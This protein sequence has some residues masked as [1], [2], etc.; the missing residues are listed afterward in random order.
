M[1][2]TVF[3]ATNRKRSG[4][5]TKITDYAGE[6]G[7]AGMPGRVTH[8]MAHVS[9]TDL[10]QLETGRIDRIDGVSPDAFSKAVQADLTGRKNLLIFLHGF[11]NGFSDSITRT[12]F[13]REWLALGGSDC[14]AV[15]FSW[16]SGGVIVSGESLVPGLLAAPMS[17]VLLTAGIVASPWAN[18]YLADQKAAMASAADVLSFLDR[19]HPIAQKVRARGGRVI[20]MA[21]S[22]GNLVLQSAL[23]RRAGMGL[24][25][26]L[27]FE[28]AIS[29]AADTA[30]E[31]M[32]R[33]P[34]WLLHLGKVSERVSVYH[35]RADVILQLSRK[36]NRGKRLGDAGPIDIAEPG[37]YPISRFRFV[38]CSALHDDG[39]NPSLDMSHQYYR[40]IPAVRDDIAN[41]ME[42]GGP[43]GVMLLT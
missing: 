26:D 17:L 32:G 1:N 21:H 42:G 14:T 16:P 4:D 6:A 13:N 23:D 10:S 11:A 40:R 8:A 43:M 31:E 25:G 33:G 35:S 5:G 38:D 9:G 2:T 19:L 41:T 15:A 12:A 36:V 22:M 20:L 29:V 37:R 7:P 28:E 18:A 30:H 34:D 27:H 24:E 39:P 3:F